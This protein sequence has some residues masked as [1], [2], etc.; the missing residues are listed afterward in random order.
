MQAR[1]AQPALPTTACS[2]LHRT[3]RAESLYEIRTILF[4]TLVQCTQL[5]EY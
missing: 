3:L 2:M 5:D 4:A 1:R